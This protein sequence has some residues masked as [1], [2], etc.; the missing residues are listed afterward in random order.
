MQTIDYEHIPF[1]C[2]KFHEHGNLF[3]DCP[4]NIPSKERNPKANKD[5]EGFIPATR[6][7]RQGGK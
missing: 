1:R 3:R 4:L 6:N 7:C 2:K 5:K